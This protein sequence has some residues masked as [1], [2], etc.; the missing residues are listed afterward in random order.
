MEIFLKG[1][2]HAVLAHQVIH[3]VALVGV[4]HIAGAL[5]AAPLLLPYGAHGAQNVRRQLGV[6]HPRRRCLDGHAPVLSVGDAA[7]QLRGYIL[8]KGVA[9]APVQF[10]PHAHDQTRLRVGIAV[11]DLVELPHG[12][13]HFRAAAIR[14]QLVVVQILPEAL[15]QAFAGQ[16]GRGPC[17]HGQGVVPCD[18]L[19]LTQLY[20]LPDGVVQRGLV[21]AEAALVYH[22]RIGQPVAHQHLAIPVGDD[23][24]GGGHRFAGGVAGDGSGPIFAAVYHLCVIQHRKKQH[25][26]RTEKPQQHIY[27]PPGG[28]RIF[29]HSLVLLWSFAQ[30][31]PLCP[32]K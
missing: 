11:I 24:P 12:G 31:P 15:G 25:Q 18:A 1:L 21:L 9:A 29:H 32:P 20:Q 3:I 10:I 27:P 14:G 6:V 7:Q 8:G 19:L 5:V 28:V 22:Q 26:K 2:L 13:Q 4:A 16:L 17:G 23:A 30:C